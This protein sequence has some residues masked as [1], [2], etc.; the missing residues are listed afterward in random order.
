MNS[1]DAGLSLLD[2]FALFFTI[3]LAVFFGILLWRSFEN[4]C[5]KSNVPFFNLSRDPRY[6]Y[7]TAL[8][9]EICELRAKGFNLDEVQKALQERYDHKSFY[10]QW[11]VPDT[12]AKVDAVSLVEKVIR[13]KSLFLNYAADSNLTKKKFKDL[14]MEAARDKRE[15]EARSALS[16]I[17][18]DY[19]QQSVDAAMNWLQQMMTP[20][21][22]LKAKDPNDPPETIK[23]SPNAH[24]V[25]EFLKDN[26]LISSTYSG[27]WCCL[28]KL[29][30]INPSMQFP[31][32]YRNSGDYTKE[33]DKH[34][35]NRTRRMAQL[36]EIIGNVDKEKKNTT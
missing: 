1:I 31:Q 30:E 21:F 36:N 22:L 35:E 4:M 24:Y 27:F 6:L 25:Y 34:P 23:M 28:N 20:P 8:Y 14:L 29:K 5:N 17:L 19:K 15:I 9:K 26:N 3:A 10:F 16:F 18:K 13:D 12:Q 7:V 33:R 32:S 2:Y 11:E